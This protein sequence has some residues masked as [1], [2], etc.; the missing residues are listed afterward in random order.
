MLTEQEKT[1]LTIEAGTGQA[2]SIVHDE[3]LAFF[4]SRLDDAK[5]LADHGV[6]LIPP[7]QEDN[8]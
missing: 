6:R 7:G 2:P 4:N 3:A 8:P 1:I 5:W